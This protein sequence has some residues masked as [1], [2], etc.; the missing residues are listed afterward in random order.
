MEVSRTLTR[1]IDDAGAGPHPAIERAPEAASTVVDRFA[2]GSHRA[3]D[4]IAG[5]A[6]QAVNT[7]GV[8]GEELK[9]AQARVMDACRSSVREHPVASLGIALAAGFVLS[10]LLSSRS[11]SDPAA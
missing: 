4:K 8:K 1:T 10:R 7:L 5:V 9:G 11:R 3:V 2:S 6:A